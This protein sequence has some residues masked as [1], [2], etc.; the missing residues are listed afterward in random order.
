[1]C[2]SCAGVHTLRQVMV[3]LRSGAYAAVE[4]KEIAQKLNKGHVKVSLVKGLE[5]SGR[6]VDKWRRILP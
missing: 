1:M 3:W 2:P 5:G 6:R 4:G